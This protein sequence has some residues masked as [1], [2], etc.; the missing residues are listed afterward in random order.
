VQAALEELRPGGRADEN[1][2]GG[3]DRRRSRRRDDRRVARRCA[4]R[5]APTGPRPAS[6]R[7]AAPA[8]TT[9][10]ADLRDEVARVGE[11]ARPHAEDPRRQ[12]GLDGHSNGAE[13]IAVR[14][15]DIG[16][17]VVFEG[18]RLTPRRSPARP[19]TRACT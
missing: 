11:A 7:P 6:A 2:D 3:D 1:V 8:P 9:E 15:R 10:V 14:A 19:S 12:A 18:I 4:T 5:S 17:D 16:M 13:Q